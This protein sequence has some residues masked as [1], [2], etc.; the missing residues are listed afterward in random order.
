MKTILKLTAA[1]LCFAVAG[2]LA[3]LIYEQPDSPYLIE[4]IGK[5]LFAMM[6]LWLGFAILHTIKNK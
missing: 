5:Y 1:A 6:P 4:W 3:H 2:V